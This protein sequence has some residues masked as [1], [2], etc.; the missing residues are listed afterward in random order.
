MTVEI[1]SRDSLDATM[2][3]GDLIAVTHTMNTASANGKQFIVVTEE[4]GP[5]GGGPCAIEIKNITRMREVPS[6]AVAPF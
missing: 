4:G 3:E 5:Y 1:T 2:I 6:D